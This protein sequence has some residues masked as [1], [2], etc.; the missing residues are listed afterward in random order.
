VTLAV[1]I[2]IDFDEG[3]WLDAIVDIVP[4]LVGALSVSLSQLDPEVLATED[5]AA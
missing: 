1:G 3:N 4:D 5:D 2:D